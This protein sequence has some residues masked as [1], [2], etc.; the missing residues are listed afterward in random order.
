MKVLEKAL[1][2]AGRDDWE[3]RMR[4]RALLAEL[5]AAAGRRDEAVEQSRIVR[6]NAQRSEL[7]DKANA[8]LKSSN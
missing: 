6:D 7:I 4:S 8:F 2:G 1:A 5:Y 3:Y